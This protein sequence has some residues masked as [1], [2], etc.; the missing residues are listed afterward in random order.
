MRKQILVDQ[1]TVEFLCKTFG[2]TRMAVWYALNYER[3]SEKA[4][5]IRYLALQRGGKLIGTKM[6]PE[7][8][9]DSDG[10]MTQTFG[11]R[12]KLTSYNGLV[13]VWIDGKVAEERFCTEIP[14]FVALQ[15]RVRNIATKLYA[16]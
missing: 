8:S 5:K 10:V 13:T 6:E 9:F 11:T 3:N 2:C 14:E 4:I 16:R 1:D 7:T 12:I 15:D